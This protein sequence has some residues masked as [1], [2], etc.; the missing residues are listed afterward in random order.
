MAFSWRKN[1]FMMVYCI[2]DT[3]FHGLHGYNISSYIYW[4]FSGARDAQTQYFTDH[5]CKVRLKE[6]LKL[7]LSWKN[8]FMMV[9]FIYDTVFYGLHGYNISSYISWKCKSGA[10]DVQ[11]QHFTDH[12]DHFIVQNVKKKWKNGYLWPFWPYQNLRSCDLW[13]YIVDIVHETTAFKVWSG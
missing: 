8:E 1:E 11:T 6:C 2:Y 4:K 3:V 12:H 13:S 5:Q 10:R 7:A 9:Y